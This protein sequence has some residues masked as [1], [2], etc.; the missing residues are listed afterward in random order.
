MKKLLLFLGVGSVVYGAWRY[1]AL[2][3]EILAKSKIKL[4]NI[5]IIEKKRDNITLKISLNIINN[6]EYDFTLKKYDLAVFL[7]NKKVSSVQNS[8]VNEKLAGNGAISTISFMASFNP[9]QFDLLDML[10]QL[11]TTLGK[12][13]V[14][15]KGEIQIQKGIL[16]INL[17]TDLSYKLE[18]FGKG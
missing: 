5:E 9:I 14:S 10:A 17:P 2:Q 15:V 6:S 18:D 16:N 3:G 4:A 1:Y 12:T 13:L 11:L 8:N 7:N